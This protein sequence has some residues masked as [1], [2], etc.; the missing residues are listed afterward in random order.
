MAVMFDNEYKFRKEYLNTEEG[1][2]KIYADVYPHKWGF[3]IPC[4]SGVIWEQQT[5]G[6]CCHHVLVEGVFIPLRK[7]YDYH[8]GEPEKE[9]EDLLA[10]LTDANYNY[11]ENGNIWKRIKK[12]MA[13]DFEELDCFDKEVQN[14]DGLK[15]IKLIK[16]DHGHGHGEIE[17][18]SCIGKE[19]IL[20]Y[21]NSD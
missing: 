5:D 17:T 11:K 2:S 13:F 14:Q 18:K 21:P 7:P 12:A 9:S 10:L 15:W 19:M 4:D 6:V 20:I 3:L 1:R 16:W 8:F